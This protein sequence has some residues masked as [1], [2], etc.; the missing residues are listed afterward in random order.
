MLAYPS[1]LSTRRAISH[2][3]LGPVSTVAVGV[4]PIDTSPSSTS[5]SMLPAGETL[6]R[7][8][9]PASADRLSLK[10][11][12]RRNRARA[13]YWRWWPG[14]CPSS[15]T[16]LRSWCRWPRRSDRP[17]S[18]PSRLKAPNTR[19][20]RS[21]GRPSPRPGRRGG[22][23]GHLTPLVAPCR[24][25]IRPVERPQRSTPFRPQSPVRLR[26]NA[27]NPHVSA[28]KILSAIHGEGEL[29]V[30]KIWL[31]SRRFLLV[32]LSLA[33]SSSRRPR[34]HCL[35]KYWWSTSSV[36]WFSRGLRA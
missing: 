3:V 18:H 21:R 35:V 16:R 7:G 28:G 29:I 12:P 31:F 24:D 1:G 34:T 9:Y 5:N 15:R 22:G 14:W 17:R 27:C 32:S 8:V 33:G 23:G 36:A 11:N 10:P 25:L 19:G 20:R 2:G 26:T 13:R 4:A 6:T 30:R